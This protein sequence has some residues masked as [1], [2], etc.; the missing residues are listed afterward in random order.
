MLEVEIS[1]IL[2]EELASGGFEARILQWVPCGENLPEQSLTLY[3]GRK[4]A[5]SFLLHREKAWI[6]L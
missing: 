5:H 3:A 2:P 1:G 6:Y 4:T